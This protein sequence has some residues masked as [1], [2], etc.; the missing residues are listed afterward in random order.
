MRELVKQKF[1]YKKAKS[2]FIMFVDSDD[3][4]DKEAIKKN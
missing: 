1:G 2:E 4:I 3:Y